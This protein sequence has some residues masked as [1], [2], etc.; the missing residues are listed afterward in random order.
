MVCR[1]TMVAQTVFRPLS[2]LILACLGVMGLPGVISAAEISWIAT[3]GAFTDGSNWSGGAVPTVGDVAVIANGGEAT[4]SLVGGAP[5]DGPR[6]ALGRDGIGTLV[7]E[8]S[9]S[10]TV[11]GPAYVGYTTTGS[12]TAGAGTL[13]VGSG[14]TLTLGGGGDAVVGGSDDALGASGSI[15]IASG[16]ELVFNA[17]GKRLLVGQTVAGSTS[18]GSIDVAGT[19]TIAAGEFEV[20]RGQGGGGTGTGTLTIVDGGVVTA[21]DWTKFGGKPFGGDGGGGLGRLVISGGTFNKLGGG[22]LV[23]GDYQA[24]GEA[25]QTGG[26]VNVAGG[27]GVNVGAFGVE[28]VGSYTISGGTLAVDGG[29]LSIGRQNGQGTFT[30][31]GGLVQKTGTGDLEVGEGGQGAGTMSVTGGLVEVIGGD[32][33]VGKYGGTGTLS[34]GGTGVVRAGP[35]VMSKLGSSLAATINLDAGGRLEASRVTAADIFAYTEFNFNGGRLV[36]T[37]NSTAFMT[38]VTAANVNA[39]ALIDT[40]GFSATMA[41]PL[42]GAGGLTKEGS[43]SL[44]LT[45][46]SSYTG[47]TQIEAGTL[48]LSTAGAGGGSIGIAADATLGVTVAAQYTQLTASTLTLAEGSAITIDLGSFGNPDAG[49][50]PL[51]VLGAVTT[52]GAAATINFATLAPAAGTIPLVK[53]GSLD[54][55]NFTL[56]SLPVGM[57]A[58]L[59]NNPTASQIELVVSSVPV[60]RWQGAASAAWNTTD[61]NWLDTFSGPGTAVTFADGDGPVI[62]DDTATGPTSISLATTVAPVTTQFTNE[63]LAYSLT[64][65]GGI[66]GTGGLT[67]SGAGGLTLATA[68]SFT[69][70]VRLVGGTTSVATIANGGVTSP[71]GAAAAD[72]ANLVFAGGTLAYTGGN[73]TTNRGFSLAGAGGGIEVAGA[74]TTLSFNARITAESGAFRKTG[75]GH[76]RFLGTNAT[77]VI[78]A[79]EDGPGFIVEAGTM[80]LAGGTTV[81]TSLVNTMTGDFRLGSIPEQGAT[82]NITNATLTLDGWMTLGYETGT[83]TTTAT[84]TRAAVNAGNFRMG[85]GDFENAGSHTL[86]LNNAALNVTGEALIGNIAPAVATVTVGGSSSIR[87]GGDLNIGNSEG[88]QGTVTVSG[89]GTLTSVGRLRVGDGGSGQLTATDT[90]RL[91][92]D[93]VQIGN[94]L[95]STG[96]LTMQSGS[97]MTATGYIAVGNSG[98]GT[99]AMSGSAAATVQYDFNVGDLAGG[100]GTFTLTDQATV[101]AGSFF[102][103]KGDATVASITISGGEFSQTNADGSFVVGRDG[104]ATLTLSGTGRMTAAANSGLVLGESEFSQSAVVNL[105]GGLLQAAKVSK[106]LGANTAVVF[107]GGTLQARPTS[108]GS[109]IGGIDSLVVMAGGAVID[110]NGARIAIDQA[111]ADGGG[112]GLTKAGLGT[113]ALNQANF[114]T[115]P[116]TVTA[117]T[118]QLNG[119]NSLATGP[120]TVQAGGT[121]AGTG[122]VGGETTL[123][124]DATLAPGASPGTL[125][126]TGGMTWAS[127]ANY[128]WQLLDAAGTAGSGWDLAAIGGSLAITATAADPVAIN[129]WTLSATGPDVNGPAANFSSTAAGSWTIATAAGGITGFSADAFTVVTAPANGTAGFANDVGSGSFSVAQAGNTLNLVFTPGSGPAA[130]VIDV[131]S[132]TQSQAQAGYPTIASAVSVTKIGAGTVVFDAANAYT[133]PTTVSAGTLE[134]ANPAGL[135]ATDVTVDTGATLAVASGTT[136]RAPAVIIDGGTLSA[137]SVAVNNTTG[138]TSLAINA[139]TVAGA[140]V[141]TVG[142]GGQLALV[143]DARVTIS[144][145]G[146]SVDQVGGGGRLDLGAGQVSI[147][148]GGIAAADLRADIIAGRNGGAWNGTAGITSSTAASSGGTRAVGYVVAGD[149]SARV[150]YSAAGDVDLS[151]A[152][153]VFDLVSINSSGKYGSGTSSVWSQGD[154]NYDGVTNVFD[155]VGVNTAGAYGQGNYFPAAPTAGSLGTAAAVPEPTGLLALAGGLCGLSQAACRRR[156]RRTGGG[157]RA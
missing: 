152:V 124:A 112:G 129:L 1:R 47:P 128:N 14:T 132:G 122:T 97:S 100:N 155:L 24:T 73:A 32:L 121:L 144:V 41:Q 143:Q 86:T 43:G 147:A 134:V 57:Q 15:A 18:T 153:N 135:Q 93:Q 148:A 16:G 94:Q 102:A 75:P 79:V 4:L 20:G 36:A 120:V 17:S 85:Y 66:G 26:L 127:G 69:G 2:G 5:V 157:R 74:S 35:V 46:A 64:G 98:T 149:G 87:S 29:A 50:A 59:Q 21:N 110:S 12:V 22:R 61:A 7:V 114:Y 19:L 58:T 154:F 119:D 89:T 103:G 108:S 55:Y 111:F 105:D 91:T 25:V 11:T 67:K 142:S 33:A 125:S 138:I 51:N 27:E 77:N 9:G 80:T 101:T 70:A 150:S 136:M 151:G 39:T 48:T 45:G 116:T 72:P 118:L 38:G 104:S 146:L 133:G 23:F 123:S 140:P 113:L 68:N 44:T 3:A 62:F 156:R 63:V 126:F 42:A 8:G 81:P 145:G 71:L 109:F 60:R 99:L 117:G 95:L 84:F 76:L 96:T 28:G 54:A 106:G 141:V 34:I 78:A 6:I 83:A 115:G 88:A 37:G 131:P 90:A 53:Y 137:A 65:A 40:Q 56:G 49:Y 139:G 82:L 130:I 30:M 107:N 10:A 13:A 92:V 52:G 31:T